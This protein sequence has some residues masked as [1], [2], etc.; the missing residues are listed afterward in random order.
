MKRVGL[1]RVHCLELAVLFVFIFAILCSNFVGFAAECEDISDRVLRLHILANSDSDADQQLKLKVRDRILQ[2]TGIMFEQETNL[3]EA[4]RDVSAHLDDIED[5]AQ[6]EVYRRGYTYD[7]QAALV[8]DMYFET[9]TYGDV[10]LP[11]GQYDALR[12]TIGAAQGHNWWCV[13]YPPLC[14]PAAEPADQELE[15]TLT[16][17]EITLVES[18]PTYDVRFAVVEIYEKIKSKIEG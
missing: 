5:I 6:D 3:E 10:T 15:G 14:L 16:E 1:K 9:R 4:K 12:I 7:V 13:L 18:D 2:E 8:D 17:D 11:A